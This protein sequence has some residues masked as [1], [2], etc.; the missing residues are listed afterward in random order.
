MTPMPSVNFQEDFGRAVQEDPNGPSRGGDVA[1]I[2]FLVNKA[3]LINPEQAQNAQQ[4]ANDEGLALDAALVL[5]GSLAESDLV[6]ALSKECWVPHL[7]VDKY[8]IRKKA[9]STISLEDIQRFGVFPVDKLGSILNLAM[10]NLLDEAAIQHID[11]KTGL[12]VKKVVTSRSEFQACVDKYFGNNA[13][14]DD[15][16]DAGESRM[17]SQDLPAMNIGATQQLA[18]ANVAEIAPSN[19]DAGIVLDEDDFMDIADIEDLLG[20]DDGEVAPALIESVAL[21]PILEE[22]AFEEPVASNDDDLFHNFTDTAAVAQEP[23]VFAQPEPV[24]PAPETEPVISAPSEEMLDLEFS[25]EPAAASNAEAKRNDVSFL[26]DLATINETPASAAPI[27]Q[28][29]APLPEIPAPA[30]DA[31]QR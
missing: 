18:N 6:V 30:A 2:E 5:N 25:P 16:M 22:P 23:D 3:E 7:K 24:I 26:E 17:F 12:E 4:R 27:P 1:L 21:E 19:D 20:A 28:I 14:A 15:A 9:L 13:Q 8:E 11:N 10:I 29:P 31:P